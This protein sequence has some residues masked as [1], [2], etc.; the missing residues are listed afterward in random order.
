MNGRLA[1]AQHPSRC[2]RA[3]RA[4]DGQEVSQVTP[5]EHPSIIHFCRRTAQTWCCPYGILR[6]TVYQPH[7]CSVVRADAQGSRGILHQAVRRRAVRRAV[8]AGG[9]LMNRMIGCL[10]WILVLLSPAM[11]GDPIVGTWRLQSFV[12]EV[13]ATGQRYNEFGEHPDGYV[14]YLPDG[15]M[16]AILVT[17]NRPKPAGPVP[18]DND[19]I[20]LFGTI[21]AYA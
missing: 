7:G 9:M 11:A 5:F 17:N 6:P 8:P 13:T 3:T 15:R 14:S 2:K 4:G 1:G 20:Q 16:H 21:I 12:R 19:K 18:T 10:V